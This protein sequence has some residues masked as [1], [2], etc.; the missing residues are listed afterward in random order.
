MK[1]VYVAGPISPDPL[2]HTR[3]ALDAGSELMAA[4]IAPFVPHLAC[5]WQVVYPRSYEDWMRWDAEWI[6]RC[7][8]LLRLPGASPGADREMLLAMELGIP[9]FTLVSQI[10]E[11]ARA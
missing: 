11:W 6:R 4:G 1:T 3:R 10:I 2:G 7:D 8:A 5:L 9:I